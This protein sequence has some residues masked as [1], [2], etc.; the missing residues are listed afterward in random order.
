LQELIPIFRGIDGVND[1]TIQD[2]NLRQAI[3]KYR[4]YGGA[5]TFESQIN[6]L[7]EIMAQVQ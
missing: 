1:N 7:K 6:K 5:G 2:Q 3:T 4:N